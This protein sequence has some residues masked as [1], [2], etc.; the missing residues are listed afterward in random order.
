MKR[1]L[2]SLSILLILI[3]CV[4][5]CG[6]ALAVTPENDL[7]AYVKVTRAGLFSTADISKREGYL[8][9]Y[10]V[11]KVLEYDSSKALVEYSQKQY[12]MNI[13]HLAA[14]SKPLNT[15]A[16]V[17]RQSYFYSKPSTSASKVRLDKG[18]QVTVLKVKGDWVMIVNGPKA[19]YIKKGNLSSP[20]GADSANTPTVQNAGSYSLSGNVTVCDIK[21]SPSINSLPVYAK[22]SA[23]S[24]KL[25]TIGRS[26]VVNVYAYNSTWAYIELNGHFGYTRH[27]YLKKVNVTPTPIPTPQADALTPCS[28]VDA[29][30]VSKLRVYD[31]PSTGATYLGYLNKDIQVSVSAYNSKWAYITVNGRSGY[32]EIKYLRKLNSATP[33][34]TPSPSPTPTPA[35]TPAPA[36]G[37]TDPIFSDSSLS[38][39]QKIYKYLTTQTQY[40]EAV[41]CGILANIK[42]ESAFNP[43]SGQGKNYQGLCQ[44]STTRFKILSDWCAQQGFDSYSLEGQMKFLKYDLE[45]RYIVYHK[46][47]LK[48]ENTA[49]G[50]YDA[51]YYFCYH[52]ERPA[53]VE[54]SSDKRGTRARDVF[55]PKY[56]N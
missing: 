51:G 10:D 24:T 27:A 12:Y 22:A 55:W 36:S 26:S 46:A 9:R 21:A 6:A 2:R 1:I 3:F 30:V 11:V 14:V 38:N 52:Y 31:A 7:Y 32:A 53:N 47:L 29:V 49:Q 40:N 37:S 15:E 25:G 19:G 8:Y 5:T 34:P 43:K 18:T 33:T 50:A 42:Q 35:P 39:E 13:K 44:W 48:I 41:A 17:N 4:Q 20:G 16:E 45:A 23:S 54:T 28:P 56:A